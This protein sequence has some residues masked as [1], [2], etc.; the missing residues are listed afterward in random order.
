MIAQKNKN[1]WNWIAF[2]LGPFW[3][4]AKGMPSKGFW[5]LILCIFTL[6]TSYPFLMFYCGARGNSDWYEY[7]LKLRGRINFDKV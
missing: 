5:M 2:F 6:F 3:Y 4:M 1:T 7:Q